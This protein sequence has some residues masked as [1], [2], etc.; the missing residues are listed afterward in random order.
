[1]QTLS[2][3]TLPLC[4]L[5]WFVKTKCVSWPATLIARSG[6][7]TVTYEQIMRLKTL[8]DLEYTVGSGVTLSIL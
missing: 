3:I 1:M 2:L 5:G 7:T 8:Q 4:I 6:K